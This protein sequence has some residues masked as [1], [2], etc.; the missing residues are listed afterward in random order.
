MTTTVKVKRSEIKTFINTTPATTATYKLIGDGV[1]SGKIN[2]NP[3]TTDET[4]I[5]QDSASISVDS[6]AP[7]MPVEMIAKNGEDVFEFVDGLRKARAVLSAAE[8]DIVNVWLYETA[9]SGAYPAEKQSVSI[10]IDDFGGDGGV[11][12]RINY[13]INYIGNAVLGTFNPTTATFTAS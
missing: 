13:T 10:Q 9:V 11:A 6:Y 12:A 4:Y 8:T 3:K 2:Y 7:V 1:T 5:H